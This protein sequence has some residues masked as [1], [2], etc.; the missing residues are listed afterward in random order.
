MEVRFQCLQFKSAKSK[1]G[2]MNMRNELRITF[3][4]YSNRTFI[5]LLGA[6]SLD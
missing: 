1:G 5:K 3:E 6:L 4:E 2:V